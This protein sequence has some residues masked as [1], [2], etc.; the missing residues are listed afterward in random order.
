MVFVVFSDKVFIFIVLSTFLIKKRWFSPYC[1]QKVVFGRWND[2]FLLRLSAKKWFWKPKHRVFAETV[3][4]KL[5]CGAKIVALSWD[6]QLKCVLEGWNIH[7]TSS[8]L[9]ARFSQRICKGKCLKPAS[10]SKRAFLKE[11]VKETA[12]NQLQPPN[13]PFSKDLWRKVPQTSSSLQMSF[14]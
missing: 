6:C 14:P 13:E 7:Q 9:R 2:S 4:L 12:S 3:S 1:Q 11:F 5:H 8:S 10:A